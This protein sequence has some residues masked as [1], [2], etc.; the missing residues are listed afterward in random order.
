MELRISSPCPFGPEAQRQIETSAVF[1]NMKDVN[2]A[3]GLC[4][5]GAGS[6]VLCIY[7]QDVLCV[8]FP[9]LW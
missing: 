9:V 6:I 4:V 7:W 2:M 5:K 8:A 1:V 3:N